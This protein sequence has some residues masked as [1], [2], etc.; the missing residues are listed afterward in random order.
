MREFSCRYAP[1]G[2]TIMLLMRASEPDFSTRCSFFIPY[3]RQK[4]KY[5]ELVSLVT[6]YFSRHAVDENSRG[7]A[8]I[9][10]N[11]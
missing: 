6:S 5:L 3:S 10:F 2:G 4:W 8:S 1:S 11:F 9:I 7:L